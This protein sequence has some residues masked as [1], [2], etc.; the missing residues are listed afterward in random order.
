MNEIIEGPTSTST[1]EPVSVNHTTGGLG[2]PAELPDSNME[3]ARHH[4]A[5]DSGVC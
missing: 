2:P 1:T 3:A 5:A 4:F